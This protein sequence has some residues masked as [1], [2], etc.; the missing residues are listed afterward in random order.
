MN[1]DCSSMIHVDNC[2]DIIIACICCSP[3]RIDYTECVVGFMLCTDK[4]SDDDFR[5]E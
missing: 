2:N 4:Y 1:Q 3:H 5:V